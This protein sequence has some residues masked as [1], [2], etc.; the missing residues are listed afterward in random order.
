MLEYK[1]AWAGGRLVAVPPQHTSQECPVC[2]H[3]SADNRRT[4]ARF[5]CAQCG[6]ESNADLVGAINVLAAGHE[7]TP[8]YWA[9]P[10]PT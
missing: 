6:Y 2:H 7:S 8:I 9:M 4:Q 1:L 5:A 10:C 3:V